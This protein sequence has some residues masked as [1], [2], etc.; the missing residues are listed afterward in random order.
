MLETGNDVYRA[1]NAKLITVPPSSAKDFANSTAIHISKNNIYLGT[2]LLSDTNRP[3]TPKLISELHKLKIKTVMLT[4]DTAE[5]AKFTAE[6][7]GIAEFHGDLLPQD[8]YELLDGFEL[9]LKE[10]PG[11]KTLFFMGDGINDAPVLARADI[12]VA[13]GGIGSDS[14]IESADAVIMNDDPYK[15]IS[16]ISTAKKTAQVVK[17]NIIFALSVKFAVMLLAV[18]GLNQMWHAVFADVG[19]CLI[20]VANT[21]IQINKE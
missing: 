4:G 21:V 12:G 16:A 6:Q 11:K 3:N 20:A 8:K 5:K 18:L 9:A 13:M 15:I 10:I 14:A 7:L 2:F 19:V 1:G 17:E